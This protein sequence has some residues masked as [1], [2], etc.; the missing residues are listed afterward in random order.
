MMRPG[1][2]LILAGCFLLLFCVCSSAQIVNR[3]KVDDAT[4]QR[5]AWG[6]MQQFNPS[7][8]PLADS[9]YNA[10]VAQDN[11][12]LKCLGLTLEFPV[13]FAAGEYDRMDAAVAEIKE[14]TG[15]RKDTRSFYFPVIHE[16]C[17]FLIHIG[18]ASDA[19]L[20]ARAMERI[21][22]AENKPLGHMYAHRIIGLIQSYRTNSYL[23]VSNFTKAA[24]YCK[25]ARAEQEIPNLYILIAQEYI[26]VRD[27]QQAEHF[28]RE[29]E[30]YMDYFPSLKVLTR[31]TRAIL[32]EAEGDLDNFYDT[33]DALI[34]DPLYK[35]QADADSRFG[36]DVSYLQS[37][38]LF[39]QALAK[40]DSL[41]TA[42]GRLDRKHGIYAAAG[43]YEPAYVELHSLMAEKDSIYIRVQN[44]D[45]AIL[46]A[47]MN[48]AR[49]RQE[50]ERLK[51][52][53]QMTILLGFLV[54]FAIAFFAI[55][56]SQWQLRQNLDEMRRKNN[57]MLAAR[58]AFQAAMDAKE[59]ENSFQLKIL[60]NRTTNVLTGYEDILN[61]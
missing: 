58:R 49:L 26:K 7:N 28:C 56:L 18:R 5:Y 15:A 8:L 29:A 57:Q 48:N 17:Q 43:S 39:E 23:A 46:D 22:T 33:Y 6:R 40:A 47:E 30:S 45:M 42:R 44:E 13:R 51:A 27:F 14:L 20:E 52:Q 37:H 54:M 61:L 53:N 50:A 34:S 2:K 19:M 32:Y 59:S 24:E 12:R 31:M 9:L 21:A 41:S 55:L 60:Q 38:G 35:V 25:A 3:L 16:Y 36:L 11:F 10:G 4:F 1:R